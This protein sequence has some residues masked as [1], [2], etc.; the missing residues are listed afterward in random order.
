MKNQLSKSPKLTRRVIQITS[1]S[2]ISRLSSCPIFMGK[3]P[4]LTSAKSRETSMH[5]TRYISFELLLVLLLTSFL[6][7]LLPNISLEN[8]TLFGISMLLLCIFWGSQ[9]FLSPSFIWQPNQVLCILVYLLFLTYSIITIIHNP[10]INY[11]RAKLFIMATLGLF[12]VLAPAIIASDRER[13]KRF[14]FLLYSAT[15]LTAIIAFIGYQRHG[16]EFVRHIDIYGTYLAIGRPIALGIVIGFY[17]SMSTN[18]LYHQ[19]VLLL[20]TCFMLYTLLLISGRNPIIAAVVPI[21]AY[22][23]IKVLA[24]LRGLGK[25][26]R[27]QVFIIGLL[28]ISA[29]F[30]LAYAHYTGHQSPTEQRMKVALNTPNGGQSLSIRSA[31]Y[32]KAYQAWLEAPIFGHGI[33]SFP[34][35]NGDGDVFW[36]PH[37]IFLEILCE[38]GIIGLMVFMVMVVIS[39]RT[40]SLKA[41]SANPNRLLVFLL[42]LSCFISTLTFWDLAYDYYLWLTLSLLSANNLPIVLRNRYQ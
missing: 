31:L 6:M 18:K 32:H 15:L 27:Q 29:V 20:L 26:T 2:V 16:L 8:A 13:F 1:I 25:F 11:A 30:Y 34:L 33:G 10:S 38:L 42:M 12:C 19:V 40:C 24:W 21:I 41:L 28:L 22:V 5:F 37:N 14:M 9:Q 4:Y 17:Y 7:P 23:M 3:R 35:L 39:L 36:F